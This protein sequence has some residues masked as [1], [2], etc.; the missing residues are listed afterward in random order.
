MKLQEVKPK[1]QTDW[2]GF[3]KGVRTYVQCTALMKLLRET[4]KKATHAVS[5]DG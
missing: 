1:A 3:C 5:H 4:G 2:I